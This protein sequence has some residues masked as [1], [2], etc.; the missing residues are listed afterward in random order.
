MKIPTDGI[1][2]FDSGIGGLTVLADTLPLFQKQVFLY[3]GDNNHAPYGNLPTG[4]IQK[5]VHAVFQE[6]DELDL[7]MAVLACN[8]ATAVC[9]EDLRARFAYPIVGAEPAIMPAARRGGEVLVLA[10]RATCE[11]MRF[12][13]LCD[14]ARR[15]YTHCSIKAVAC[16][17]L[18]GVIEENIGRGDFDLA[19]YL[20]HEKAT[21]VVL[22]CTHYVYSR[23]RIKEFYTCPVYDG[24]E[25]I[26]RRVRLLFDKISQKNDISRDERPLKT[27][28]QSL[29]EDGATI[30]LQDGV[31]QAQN[32]QNFHQNRGLDVDSECLIIDRKD[33]QIFFLGAQK[34]HNQHVFEQMF[35]NIRK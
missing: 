17:G 11:S 20:P 21:S 31:L 29:D 3:Y 14:K 23:E 28:T 1:L 15:L 25:G 5:N 12:Q 24:N 7:R 8:T 30:V 34:K 13:R 26:A 10:T 4:E 2:F 9:A 6:L 22:G 19:P 27:P 18:A 32:K 33:N 16:E 35:V